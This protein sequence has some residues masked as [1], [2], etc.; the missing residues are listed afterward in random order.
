[1]YNDENLLY[2]VFLKPI[3][4]EITNVNLQFQANCADHTKTYGELKMLLLSIAKRI[5][6]PIFL[7]DDEYSGVLCTEDVRVCERM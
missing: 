2:L 4:R 5:I 1:M 3:I 7:R 6:K